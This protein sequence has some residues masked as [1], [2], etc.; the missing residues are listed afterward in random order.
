MGTYDVTVSVGDSGAPAGHS[1]R[2]DRRGRRRGQQLRPHRQRQVPDRDRAGL[3]VTDGFLT[4]DAAGGTN[5]KLNF[6]EIIDADNTPRTITSVDPPNGATGVPLDTSVSLSPSHAV[7]QTTVNANTVKLLGPA[8]TRWP[9]ATTPTRPAASSSSRPRAS[10]P[11]T[12]PTRCRPR[13]ACRTRPASPSP[14]SARPSPPAPARPRRHPVNFDRTR[15]GRPH[16]PD[17][18]R[19]RPRR[20]ALRRQRHR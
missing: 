1:H 18:D 6:V 15:P 10:W 13:P 3:G 12:P 2:I 11:R 9:A 8:A 16:G 17:L 14:P 5:T 20:Q 19:H 7:E 4:L